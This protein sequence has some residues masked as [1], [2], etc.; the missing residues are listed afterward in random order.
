MQQLAMAGQQAA[1]PLLGIRSNYQI[2]QQQW[3]AL[4]HAAVRYML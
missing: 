2:H 1:C 3:A 4:M